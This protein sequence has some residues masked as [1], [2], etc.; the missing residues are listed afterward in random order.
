[1]IGSV[2]IDRL[3][4]QGGWEEVKC[5]STTKDAPPP[6]AVRVHVLKRNYKGG[7][8]KSWLVVSISGEMIRALGGPARVSVLQNLGEAA[9]MI[10]PGKD[11]FAPFK[12]Q[13]PGGGSR[14]IIMIPAWKRMSKETLPVKAEAAVITWKG[15]PALTVRLPGSLFG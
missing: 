10:E 15:A 14:G 1:M 12:L 7:G 2:P 4:A 3:P 5:D 8:Q 9:L 6:A 11:G 13:R